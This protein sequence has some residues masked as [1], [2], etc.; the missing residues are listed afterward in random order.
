V[1]IAGLLAVLQ[2]LLVDPLN[3]VLP[4]AT[5]DTTGVSGWL[6]GFADQLDALVPVSALLTV[7][8]VAATA[9][10]AAVPVIAV[11]WLWKAVRP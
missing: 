9:G 11:I 8:S 2:T 5:L 6:S 7:V 1:I 4:T 3:S 10:L